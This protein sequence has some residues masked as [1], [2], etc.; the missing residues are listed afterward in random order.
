LLIIGSFIIELVGVNT[1]RLFGVYAYDQTLGFKL[2]GVPVIIGVNWFLLVYSTGV[3]LQRTAI[4]TLWARCFFGAALLVLLDILIEPA[5]N[6]YNYW[7]W[8]GGQAPVKNY[9]G[10]F[11]VSFALLLLFEAFKI[12]RQNM[13]APVLLL[14]QFVFFLLM[15]IIGLF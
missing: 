11:S 4:N 6:T 10:W 9:L 1:G 3:T 2:L 13:V 7:H 15:F 14:S 8:V 12:K 5:A